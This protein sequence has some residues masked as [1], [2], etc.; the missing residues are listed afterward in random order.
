[1]QPRLT[2]LTLGVADLTRA[3]RFY[4]ALGWT[5][6]TY[7]TEGVAFFQVGGLVLSLYPRAAL[8]GDAGI[9]PQGHGFRG[10]ALAYNTASR[11]ETD[12]VLTRAVE[13]GATLVK[14]AEDAFWGGY[15]GYFSD[16]D[17]ALW[18][19]AWNPDLLPL[20]D[21]SVRLPA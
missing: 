11:A 2:L 13:A 17:G 3:V 15:S 6:S 1:M 9:A 5:R 19:V 18:E 14:P 7:A 4:E 8:A 21:G 20:A 12:A 16:P 10:F